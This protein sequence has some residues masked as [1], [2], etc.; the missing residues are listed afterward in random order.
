MT[1]NADFMAGVK[2]TYPDKGTAL[3]VGCAS[4]KRSTAAISQMSNEGYTDLTNLKG[5]YTAWS[6]EEQTHPTP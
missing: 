2:E 1:P 4:G 3:L 6:G 5:G